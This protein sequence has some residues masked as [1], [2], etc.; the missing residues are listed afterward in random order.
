MIQKYPGG[1]V[2]C[3]DV[4]D[5]IHA[6]NFCR[7][8][9]ILTAVR[10]GGHNGAGLGSCDDGI[11]VDL[12]H[13]N[14][15]H[16]DPA[17]K[18]ARVGAGCLLG[19]VD[20]A[21]DI[22][23]L[24]APSGIFST[25]GVG[26]LTLG[27]GLGYL[28]RKYGLA[29]DNLLEADMVLADGRYITVNKDQYADLFWAIRGG[30]GNFGIVTSFLFQLH[31]VKEV[32]G[33]PIFWEA[34]KAEQIMHFYREYMKTASDDMYG[35]FTLMVIPAAEPFPKELW[36]KNVCAVVW[37]YVG[38]KEKAEQV[39][40]PIRA[41]ATPV[42][43]FAGPIAFKDL[44]S[45]FDPVYPHG[46]NWYWKA[47]YLNDLSDEVIH[48]NVKHGTSIPTPLSQTHIYPIDGFAGRINKS[49]T[50]W[51]Y[52][53]AKF[54]QVIVAVDPDREKMDK[55]IKWCKSYWDA[56]HPYSA[57]GAYS[58]FMMEEGQERVKNA[59]G[60]N[61][62]R[63]VEIKSKYDPDNFFRVNQNIRPVGQK[64]K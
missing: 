38:E 40:Q 23:G 36:N 44:Q 24:A 14:G 32:Y 51:N 39:F 56:I 21:T 37:N 49:A 50:A 62:Q 48:E 3:R 54:V 33:G 30:G 29:I 46:L 42:L 41:F 8:N 17:K 31:S 63:L 59:Y 43:D 12:A 4:A 16:V 28:T 26:G 64:N 1:I 11:V 18:T 55:A 27:G 53:N 34:D 20:H 5:V 45:M 2:K 52:R 61:Y 15:I 19:D 7:E 10:G 25:T 9:Q 22:F 35:F 47:D 13:L 57:G 6:V 60:E 58:N